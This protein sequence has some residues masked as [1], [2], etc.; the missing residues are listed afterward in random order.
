MSQS[1]QHLIGSLQPATRHVALFVTCLVDQIM[2]EVGVAATRLLQRAGCQVDFPTEQTCCGQPFYN[3][4]FRKESARL[5]KHTIEVFEAYPAVVLPSGSCA[6]M[7]RSEYL[8]LFRDQPE[9]HERA[10]RLAAKTFELSQ[11]LVNQ[12]HWQPS[13]PPN[14]STVTYHD[15]CHTCR[16]LGVREEPRL[17]LR[18]AGYS[19]R[20]MAESDRCCG[21]GGVFS[22][23]MPETSNAITAE[24]LRLAADT[25]ASLLVTVDPGCL[26]QIR[27]LA[28]AVDIRAEH[29]AV[30]LEEAT[31]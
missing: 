21:F 20:E 17:L 22:M 28:D 25:N 27:G 1:S 11:F 18:C 23:R 15:S 19:I 30:V 3:G 6:A 9:W 7:I 2:P 10:R 12:I 24:K 31:R 8:H 14:G 29:L 26:M 5:A 4:G 16:M 13:K